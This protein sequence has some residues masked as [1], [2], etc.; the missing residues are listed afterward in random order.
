MT[1]RRRWWRRWRPKASRW[2]SATPAGRPSRYT[3]RS[4]TPRASATCSRATSRAPCTRPTATRAPPARWACALVTSGPGATNTVTGIAT[5][6]MDSVPL[7][8]I[9]G[10]VPRGVI[11]TDSF[12]ESDIV[13][14]TM[15]VVKHSYLLQTADEL[16]RHV[17]RGVPH[18]AQP[19]ARPRAHRRALRPRERD[20]VLR[21]PA[22]SEP[23]LVQAH[24]PRQCQAGP[25]GRRAHRAGQPPRA[26][27][28]RRRVVSSGASGE[29]LALAELM[30]VPVATTLMGKGA[31]P[32]SHPLNLG[33]VGMHGSKFANLALTE[34]DL[35]VAAGARFSDRVTGK[36]SEFAPHADVVHIDIDP[37]EIGKV[38]EAQVPIVRRR[39]G[40]AGK[41]RGRLGEGGRQAQTGPWLEQ[42]AQWRARYPLY[43]PNVGDRPDEIVAR[44]GDEGAFREAGPPCQ[45][46]GH[47]SG[48]APDVG[49][50]AHRARGAAHV[51]FLGRAGHHG[52]RLP[53]GHR[54]GHRAP[55]RAGGVRGGRRVA[56]NEQPGD[57]HRRRERRA[58]EGC[59]SWRQPLPRHGAPVAEAVLPRA[60]LRH[61]S[62][63]PSP[64][65]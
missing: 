19:A 65:S 8:V 46:R 12:Q 11:G 1:G 36:L 43:H 37:A 35:I 31:F 61:A 3:T 30:Q 40:R 5:A 49:G 33:P 63:T 60:L 17:L 16:A 28:R 20:A 14:I 6:Y 48:A 39:Q 23:A 59:S 51:P 50:A 57:G 58:G 24:L 45:R 41:H 22:R 44:T 13:G 7:V 15:P 18:R 55:G 34:S 4:T 42:V 64:T 2:C 27:R 62:R 25:A 21:V 38:R 32:A 29:L 10:Q 56:S 47:R 26:L 54:R 9:T 53:G 52:V